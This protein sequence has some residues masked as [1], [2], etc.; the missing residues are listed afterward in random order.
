MAIWVKE[1]FATLWKSEDKG[2]YVRATVST[3]EKDR[4]DETKYVNSNWN[5]NFVGKAADK[6]RDL[7]ERTRFKIL[8]GKISTSLKEY[9][10]EKRSFTNVAIF[11]I[12]F[13]ENNT[14]PVQNN[15]PTSAPKNKSKPTENQAGNNEIDDDSLPF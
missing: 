5:A 7:P 4:E 14:P 3:S 12:E 6:I 2:N 10:G 9:N 13:P 1:T 8:S 11:D 15:K